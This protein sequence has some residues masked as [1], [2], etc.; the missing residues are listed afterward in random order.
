MNKYIESNGGNKM[1]A[2]TILAL[3]LLM[4][5]PIMLVFVGITLKILIE[6]FSEIALIYFLVMGTITF[7]LFVSIILLLSGI[8]QE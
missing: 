7:A 1:A 6:D 3:I 2:T 8:I 4:F 5:L